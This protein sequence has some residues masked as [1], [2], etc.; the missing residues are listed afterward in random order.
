LMKRHLEDRSIRDRTA[1]FILGTHHQQDRTI[2]RMYVAGRV[3]ATEFVA[4]AACRRFCAA[5]A[6]I[7]IRGFWS[8][9]RSSAARE[10]D[11]AASGRRGG[12]SKTPAGCLRYGAAGSLLTL[13]RD[14]HLPL[15][16]GR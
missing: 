2:H 15:G 4:Q 13:I 14:R 5:I 10:V 11:G 12:Q 7:S 3:V 16:F 9:R 1:L 8:E 6:N